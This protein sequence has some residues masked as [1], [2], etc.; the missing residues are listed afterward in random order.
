MGNPDQYT[1]PKT[2]TEDSVQSHQFIVTVSECTEDEA[3]QIITERLE[4]DEDYGF[5]YS[6]EWSQTS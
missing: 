6:I 1:E 5:P 3:K 4:F 2:S